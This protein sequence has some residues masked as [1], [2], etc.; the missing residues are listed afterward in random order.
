VQKSSEVLHSKKLKS[1]K[2]EEKNDSVKNVSVIFIGSCENIR[3][4]WRFYDAVFDRI[5]RLS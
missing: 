5:E 1:D 3:K 2:R 4:V